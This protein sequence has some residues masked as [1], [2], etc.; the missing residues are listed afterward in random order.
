MRSVL[1]SL[2]IFCLPPAPIGD[3]N[4][5]GN[6]HRSLLAYPAEM[7]P[8]EFLRSHALGPASVHC[9]AADGSGDVQVLYSERFNG[10]PEGPVGVPIRSLSKQVMGV[11]VLR[12]AELARR[13]ELPDLSPRSRRLMSRVLD[14]RLSEVF[15]SCEV[16]QLANA[17]VSE[18]LTMQTALDNRL[19]A[20]WSY[21]TG[22]SSDESGFPSY[23][24]V[25]GLTAEECVELVICPS[26]ASTHGDGRGN[27]SATLARLQGDMATAATALSLTCED[28][29]EE[30]EGWAAEGDC[31]ANPLFMKLHCTVSCK[32]CIPASCVDTG[33][34]EEVG[35]QETCRWPASCVDQDALCPFWAKS[36]ECEVNAPFMRTQ[37]RLSCRVCTPSSCADHFGSCPIWSEEGECKRNA[38]FMLTKCR[39]SCKV[40]SPSSCEKEDKC[41]LAVFLH[42]EEERGKSHVTH[43]L[44]RTGC[45]YDNYSYALVAAILERLTGRRF[46]QWAVDLIAKPVGMNDMVRCMSQRKRTDT[47]G[48]CFAVPS[49]P[50]ETLDASLWPAWSGGPESVVWAGAALFG[51][52][53]DMA[54]LLAMLLND[55]KVGETRVLSHESVALMLDDNTRWF[56]DGWAD[57]QGFS[58][59]GF[60]L[61][62]CR[63]PGSPTSD[64]WC[65]GEYWGWGSVYGSRVLA[66]RPGAEGGV[67]CATSANL[68]SQRQELDGKLLYLGRRQ[69]NYSLHQVQGLRALFRAF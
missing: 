17:T 34:V 67:V 4:A 64:R 55:G 32:S 61:G 28:Q 21:A 60:G 45:R 5:L 14:I 6:L 43:T 56:K 46:W 15:P 62:C 22:A 23:C 30:C 29:H 12:L 47:D 11:T 51:S 66:M 16:S 69:H 68:A 48:R 9:V 33:T 18:M 8:D 50:A 59:F 37:C 38:P 36:G 2:L 35:D 24:D 3:E 52:A 1:T 10:F 25:Q 58:E 27:V 65:S 20:A 13:G 39:L 53:K 63:R 41:K 26:Y 19:N 57:C 40:C 44:G 7:T 31:E 49:S 42:V 54:L